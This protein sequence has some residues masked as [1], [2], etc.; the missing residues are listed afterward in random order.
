MGHIQ[1]QEFYSA[2]PGF[3]TK[4]VEAIAKVVNGRTGYIMTPTCTP[5]E[6]PCSPRY[7]RNFLEWLDA[8]ERLL[9]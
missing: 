9:R 7:E 2:P 5:F 8:A 4:R 1:D 3:M 6:H